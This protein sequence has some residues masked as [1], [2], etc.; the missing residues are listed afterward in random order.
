[1]K[2]KQH[3]TGGLAAAGL[4]SVAGWAQVP[5]P[6][7][8]TNVPTVLET[9]V[10]TAESESQALVQEP[11]LP[12]VL[13]ERIF[14]GKRTSVIDLDAFPRVQANNYRQALALT[15]GLL[16]S[17][18]TTPLVSLGY[19]GIGEPHRSQ[20]LQVLQDGVPIH[21][22]PFG[23]PEAYFTPPLDVV[24]RAEFIRGGGSLMYGPQPAGALNYVTHQPRRDREF[25]GRSQHVLGS[26]GLYSTYNAVDG[27]VG[28]LGYLAY[29]NHRQADG[30]RAANSDYQLDGGH[31]KLVLDADRDSRW[32]LALDAYEEN[33]GEP[34][35][36]GFGTGPNDA[37]YFADRDQASRLND[38]F[39]LRRYVPSLEYQLTA[40]DRTS[41]SVKTWGGYYE[42]YSRRQRGGGFGTRPNGANANS[43][44]IERQE[45]Y[46]FGLEP[47]IRHDWE[48]WN[49]GHTLAAGFQFYR[50]DSPR[51]DV[52]GATATATTGVLQRDAQR[53]VYY[54]S[55][56]VENRF[57]FGRLSVTPGF[58][59]E[60][61][62]QDL[63]VRNFD[64]STGAF[65]NDRAKDK[66]DT[67][68]LFGLG[69]AYDLQP[70]VQ[71]YGNVSQGYRT[72][73]FTESLIPTPAATLDQDLD[74]L[75]SWSYE[76]GFRGNPEP[77]LTWDTSLFLVDLDNKFGGTVVAGGVTSLR[78]VG[79]T[80]NRGWDAAVQFDLVGA[81]D[82]W[83]GTENASSF[84]SFDLYGN[85]MLLDAE[86]RGGTF[87][88]MTPQYAPDY[89]L[90]TGVIYRWQQRLKLAFLG[91]FVADHFATDDENPSRLVPAY[92]TWDLTLEWA[93][94]PDRLR[95]L[96]GINNIF[97]EDYY[98]RIRSDGIDPA[99]GRNFYAGA[100]LE[101]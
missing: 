87:G 24:D 11:F 79:R 49:A 7:G 60:N 58:R 78:N 91:T 12:D 90:R 42:R 41:L 66:L 86:I 17:E 8:E 88:G 15:P 19:R 67:E 46:S 83:R 13:G 6:T 99:Y 93:V 72:T 30:F 73:V 62:A 4:A 26:D 1:M 54:G 96:A 69:A 61:V 71:L 33:H 98:A 3:L 80:V 27:T 28:R 18:E 70:K 74:P 36:L 32:T 10:V 37:N 52:R 89:L 97:D 76:V 77:W 45:F 75:K 29:F 64:A 5:A 95:L 92:M 23:Y 68:P 16:F 2:C 38:R 56:F 25:S 51:T 31:F 84:G 39:A 21:A 50:L 85:V 101:F 82:N 55:L 65:V 44:D 57:V 20:F 40:N 53:E 48:A 22:D 43:N 14:A 47:R 63:A 94:I 34:G 9:I 100:S 35:G 59:L 81:L